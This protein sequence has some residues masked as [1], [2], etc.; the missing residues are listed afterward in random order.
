MKGPTLLGIVLILLGIVALVAKGIE[1]TT[2]ETVIDAGPVQVEAEEKKTL[3]LGPVAG[4]AA[5]VA[6]IVLVGV[7]RRS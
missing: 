6:G 2:H 1:Y 7:G 3:P 4:G 5:L